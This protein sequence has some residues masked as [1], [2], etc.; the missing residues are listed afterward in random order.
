M[1]KHIIIPLKNIEDYIFLLSK[2]IHSEVDIILLDLRGYGLYVKDL[3]IDNL[4]K[5]DYNKIIDYKDTFWRINDE[6]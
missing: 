5:E 2:K 6:I 1:A 3:L 4:N